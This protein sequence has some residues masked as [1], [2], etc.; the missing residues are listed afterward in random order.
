LKPL[1]RINTNLSTSRPIRVIQFGEGNFLRAFVDYAL[2]VLNRDT[3]FDGSVA[4]V[5]PIPNGLVN[6]LES[7]DGL[8]TLL[9]KGVAK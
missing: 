5:Q 2:H 1:N 7:Q 4:V 9:Q 6:L 3:A 8:Y